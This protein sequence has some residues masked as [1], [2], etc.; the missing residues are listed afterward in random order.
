[1]MNNLE[2]GP[3]DLAERFDLDPDMEEFWREVRAVVLAIWF[4]VT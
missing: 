3:G 2:T 1:M 4:S